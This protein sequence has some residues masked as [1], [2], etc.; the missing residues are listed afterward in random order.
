[1][2]S[3]LLNVSPMIAECIP[4]FNFSTKISPT[5][6]TLCKSITKQQIENR[7]TNTN[8]REQETYE[9]NKPIEAIIKLIT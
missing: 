7:N 5:C 6:I 4:H 8:G 3:W 9:G 2:Q 1:M